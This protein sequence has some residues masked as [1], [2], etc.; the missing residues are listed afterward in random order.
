MFAIKG[1][2]CFAA[3]SFARTRSSSDGGG[4][5]SDEAARKHTRTRKRRYNGTARTERLGA[6]TKHTTKRNNTKQPERKNRP[7]ESKPTAPL[8]VGTPS[9]CVGRSK[10]THGVLTGYSHG[11]HGVLTG[12]ST[13]VLDRDRRGYRVGHT[14]RR[15]A[16]R[17]RRAPATLHVATYITSLWLQRC[18]LQPI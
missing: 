6:P 18:T 4:A 7:A 5:F 13:R 1:R 9:A 17:R 12:Y 14:H 2:Y 16:R 11:T 15:S 8:R 3:S 10:G